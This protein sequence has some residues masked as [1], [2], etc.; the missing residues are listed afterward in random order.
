MISDRN[1]IGYAPEAT[2]SI[3]QREPYADS[4]GG[5]GGKQTKPAGG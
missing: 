1:V 3:H 4:T 2:I 5:R